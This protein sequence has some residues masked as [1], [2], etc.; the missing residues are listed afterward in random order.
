MN[1]SILRGA[2]RV[3]GAAALFGAMLA[4]PVSAAAAP[5]THGEAC[6]GDEGV[7]V[8][9]DFTDS[10]GD[11]EVACAEGAQDSGRAALE[12]A[13]FTPEDSMPGM[14]CAID[15][16]PDPCPEEFDGNFWSYWFANDSGEW[17]SYQVGADEAE[18]AL[19][20]VEGWRYF[21]GSAGPQVDLANLPTGGDAPA[22]AQDGDDAEDDAATAEAA[23]ENTDSSSSTAMWIGVT[24][25]I[26]AALFVI[27]AGV[28]AQKRKQQ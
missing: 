20:G 26:I 14:I 11:I 19:G 23:G 8:V 10:G 1:S 17:E 7:T 25:A 3:L 5:A 16:S 2:P 21:D 13:G 18:P 22:D 24:A 28:T 15:S 9:V 4:V 6:V 12:A 27:F